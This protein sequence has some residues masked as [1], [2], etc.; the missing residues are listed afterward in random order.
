MMDGKMTSLPE[1]DWNRHWEDYS[2]AASQNP[3]QNYRREM[4]FSLLGIRGL[5]E[6]VRL[7]DIGS[8]QGDMVA[9]V[10][11]RFPSAQALGLEL[12]QSGVE[13]SRR[14][15]PGAYF[16]QRDLLRTLEPPEELRHWATHAICSE[17]IEHMDDPGL[18]LRNARDFMRPGCV[19]I[20]T[21]PGGPMSAFDKHIGH[22]KHWC[23]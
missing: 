20:I 16:I 3:A 11:A 14:K 5:G 6:G 9:A 13:I 7:L 22:R 2:E 21:A 17:V 18:L 8:G 12:A 4:I 19:L 23:R 15:V 1:D 10:R